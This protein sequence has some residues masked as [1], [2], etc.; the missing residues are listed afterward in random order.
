MSSTELRSRCEC[1]AYLV[2]EVAPD[3]QVEKGR[4]RR[5]G[6]SEIAPAARTRAKGQQIDIGWQCPFCGRN[7]LRSFDLGGLSPA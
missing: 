3:G 2:A 7:T 6:R 1:E 5:D 4:A